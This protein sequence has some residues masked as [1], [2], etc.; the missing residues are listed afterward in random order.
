MRALVF[1]AIM[2]LFVSCTNN[3]SKTEFDAVSDAIQALQVPTISADT[4]IKVVGDTL[5]VEEMPNE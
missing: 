4:T 3:K 2:V 5:I 1:L